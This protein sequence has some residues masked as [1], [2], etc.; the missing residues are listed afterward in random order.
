MSGK[1][2]QRREMPFDAGFN[3]G[4]R[5]RGFFAKAWQHCVGDLRIVNLLGKRLE[6]EKVDGLLLEFFNARCAAFTGRLENM[7]QGLA[8]RENLVD[9]GENQR[10]RDGRGMRDDLNG[11]RGDAEI[12]GFQ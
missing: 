4:E 9:S 11:V 12:V 5:K 1:R 6:G 7:N 2:E 3:F 8:K 10:N